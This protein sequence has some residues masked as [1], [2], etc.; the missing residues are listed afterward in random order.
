M[1]VK[2]RFANNG[3]SMEQAFENISSECLK[4]YGKIRGDCVRMSVRTNYESPFYYMDFSDVIKGGRVCIRISTK[5]IM[6][7]SMPII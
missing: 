2:V 1:K 4:K 3:I 7:P 6:P 5:S